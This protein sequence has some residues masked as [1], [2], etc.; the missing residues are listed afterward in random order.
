MTLEERLVRLETQFIDRDRK[1]DKIEAKVDQ[2]LAAANMG[3]GAWW[4]LLRIGAALVVIVGFV[5]WMASFFMG[6]HP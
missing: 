4:L 2:L 1:L 6:K 3:K 5:E